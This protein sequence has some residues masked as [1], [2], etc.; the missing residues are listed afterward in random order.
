MKSARTLGIIIISIFAVLV[1]LI[2]GGWYVYQRANYVVTSDANVQGT[3]VPLTSPG[4]GTLQ[5]WNLTNGDLISKNEVI[6][7]TDGLTGTTAIQAPVAGTVVQNNAVSNE[8]VVIGQPLAYLV[9]LNNLQIIAN[10]QETE[11]N[12]V[13]VGKTVDITINAH[14]NTSFTGRVTQIGAGS[15]VVTQGVP[16]TSLS[17]AFNKQTQRVPVYISIS[18]SEGKTLMPGMSASVSIHRN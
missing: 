8:M 4:D 1:I 14:P 12:N 11:I 10:V 7:K 16:N 3:L 17:G 9:N 18:G 5:N 13:A 15:T 2:G 6:G